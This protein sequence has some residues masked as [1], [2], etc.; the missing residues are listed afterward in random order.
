MQF[1]IVDHPSTWDRYGIDGNRNGRTSPYEPADAIASCARFLASHGWRPGLPLA[2]KRR[3]VRRYNPSDPYV[4]SVLGLANRID[5]SGVIEM[6]ATETAGARRSSL[7]TST[8]SAAQ[9]MSCSA[10]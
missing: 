4:D 1:S 6:A 5:A 3:I 7:S 2:E 10:S 9:C 8:R